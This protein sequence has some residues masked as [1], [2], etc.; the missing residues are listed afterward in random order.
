[1][2]SS[3]ELESVQYLFIDITPRPTLSQSYS[4]C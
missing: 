2:V 3:K 4:T 1:M